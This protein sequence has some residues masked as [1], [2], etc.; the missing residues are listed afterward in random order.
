MS[1]IN[2]KILIINDLS[3]DDYN[4]LVK[5]QDKLIHILQ[6]KDK[7]KTKAN[8]Y[9][10]QYFKKVIAVD[11]TKMKKIKDYRLK[12]QKK[13][14]LPEAE[15]NKPSKRHIIID[16]DPIYHIIN[17]KNLLKLF[18]DSGLEIKNIKYIKCFINKSEIDISNKQTKY[19]IIFNYIN[20]HYKDQY[21]QPI[22]IK[23]VINQQIIE[24]QASPV[25]EQQPITI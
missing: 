4:L 7:M 21:F 6:N 19:N 11:E 3:E 16:S 12:Y 15:N 23:T 18:P 22:I 24:Q 5:Y 8:E 13:A 17:I 20:N 9:M 25:I 1:Q 14:D 10:K 2:N